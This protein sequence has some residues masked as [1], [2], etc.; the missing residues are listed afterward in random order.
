MLIMTV[1]I[2]DMYSSRQC[3]SKLVVIP[4]RN[5]SI[6]CTDMMLI[7]STCYPLNR[8]K[9]LNKI[10]IMLALQNFS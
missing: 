10:G 8:F 5:V 3:A 9:D 6:N 2:V 1:R 7:L 4:Y